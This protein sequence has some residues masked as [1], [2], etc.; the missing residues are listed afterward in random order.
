MAN[1][2]YK[3]QNKYQEIH[4]LKMSV[5]LKKYLFLFSK[6]TFGEI[7]IKISSFYE[8]ELQRNIAET[9][10]ITGIFCCFMATFLL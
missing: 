4:S 2:R 9:C 8:Y 1:L 3:I 5:N 6:A 7:N 10:K